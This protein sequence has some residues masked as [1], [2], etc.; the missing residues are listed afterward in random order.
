MPD[1]GLD[2]VSSPESPAAAA[3]GVGGT[4]N[5]AVAAHLNDLLSAPPNS[6]TSQQPPRP[7]PARSPYE[8]IK[9]PNFVGRTPATKEGEMRQA[10]RNQK[11]VRSDSQKGEKEFPQFTTNPFTF[12]TYSVVQNPVSPHAVGWLVTHLRVSRSRETR[13]S[14]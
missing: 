2:G 11:N 9:R 3:G 7:H 10:L 12:G 5:S 8:W 6:G 4:G 14:H 1:S 13:N